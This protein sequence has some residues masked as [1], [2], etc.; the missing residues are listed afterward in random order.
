[1]VF[2]R[3]F[4]SIDGHFADSCRIKLA[5]AVPV[6]ANGDA[7]LKWTYQRSRIQLW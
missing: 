5:I 4:G 2:V 3:A 7:T 1:M 6:L